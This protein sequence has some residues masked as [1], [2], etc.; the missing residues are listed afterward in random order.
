MSG[1][2]ALQRAVARDIARKK[3]VKTDMSKDDLRA[4]LDSY[5]GDIE[6]VAPRVTNHRVDMCKARWSTVGGVSLCNFVNP[7]ER[8]KSVMEVLKR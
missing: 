6:A 7:V 2:N 5:T 1:S 8:A 3:E 4:M